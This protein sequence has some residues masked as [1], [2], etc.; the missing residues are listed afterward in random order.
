VNPQKFE[1]LLLAFVVMTRH[2]HII[3]I[4]KH[5]GSV[6]DE[7]E[8]MKRS[9]LISCRIVLCVSLMSHLQKEIMFFACW[10]MID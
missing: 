10:K 2:P 3:P 5:Q 1:K 9:R 6:S 7:K 4:Q 8:E